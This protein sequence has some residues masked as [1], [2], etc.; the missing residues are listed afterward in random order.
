M[1]LRLKFM[2]LKVYFLVT[3]IHID[4]LESPDKDGN[5]INSEHI[6]MKGIPPSCIQYYATQNNIIVLDVYKQL[7]DNE[8]IP[9]DLTNEGNQFV[10]Q[11]I[12]ITRS[13]IPQ[14][15]QD[16]YIYWRLTL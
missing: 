15:Y 16:I 1:V 3:N 5:T 10:C 14:I 12:K 2:R 13:I 4:I 11:I 9:F 8:T 7:Y 6:I